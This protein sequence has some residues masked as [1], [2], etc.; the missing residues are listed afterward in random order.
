M[1]GRWLAHLLDGMGDR[2]VEQGPLC[3]GLGLLLAALPA[4]ALAW[5]YWR[6]LLRS[7]GRWALLAAAA[8]AG[9]VA[10]LAWVRAVDDLGG[11]QLELAT[12][13]NPKWPRARVLEAAGLATLSPRH[14]SAALV[15]VHRHWQ[16]TFCRSTETWAD[17]ERSLAKLVQVEQAQGGDGLFSQ[18][19]SA[20]RW[21]T[22]TAQSAV[23]DQRWRWV[24]PLTRGDFESAAQ[25]Y[26]ELGEPYWRARNW[27]LVWLLTAA[28]RFDRAARAVARDGL[29]QSPTRAG[30]LLA[31]WAINQS[32]AVIGCW[33]AYLEARAGRDGARN[34][35]EAWARPRAAAQPAVAAELPPPEC[36]LLAADLATGAHRRK[37]LEVWED[38]APDDGSPI[39]F[40]Y[41]A[42]RPIYRWLWAEAFPEELSAVVRELPWDL[43]GTVAWGRDLAPPFTA[44]HQ[45]VLDRLVAQRRPSPI[46]RLQRADLLMHR[47]VW[48]AQVGRIEASLPQAERALAD[49]AAFRRDP[50]PRVELRLEGRGS[51]P[52]TDP[53]ALDR[54]IEQGRGWLAVLALRA[55]DWQ[56]AHDQLAK[57]DP[58]VAASLAPMVEYFRHQTPAIARAWAEASSEGAPLCPESWEAAFEGRYERGCYHPLLWSAP[59]ATLE[60]RA[61]MRDLAR[62]FVAGYLLGGTSEF[63]HGNCLDVFELQQLVAALGA[64]EEFPELDQGVE[65]HRAL[66][67]Q[68]DR[69][70]P[71]LLL[72]PWWGECAAE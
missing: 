53:G 52:R 65:R 20:S 37:L 35:L 70:V 59:Y 15:Q 32:A 33:K 63:T 13:A 22:L 25:Q 27:R 71:L 43:P 36:V 39:A 24:G 26:G 44:L 21:Q 54:H 34:R 11:Q 46:A 69:V 8:A 67:Q 50:A 41:R 31:P 66:W 48:W 55:G 5:L 62:M 12:E 28:G 40:A 58:T 60:P 72:G 49:W 51:H 30:D 7:W 16:T 57:L 38:P 68:R 61:E 2:F 42:R 47:A 56:R 64:P 9:T 23:C 19:R 4:V 18:T 6:L 3:Y 14:R 45:R 17:H 29:S 1:W 10:A